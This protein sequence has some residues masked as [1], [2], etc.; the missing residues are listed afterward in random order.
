LSPAFCRDFRGEA[1]N[2]TLSI[3]LSAQP[4]FLLE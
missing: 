2:M 1:P 3:V 4:S